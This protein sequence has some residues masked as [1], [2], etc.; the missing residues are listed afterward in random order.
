M[1]IS[2]LL[3]LV[4]VDGSHK[5][6][7]LAGDNPI[8][9]AI[10][11]FFVMLILA[12]VELVVLIP[13]LSDGE[14]ETLKAVEHCALVVAIA[15]AGIA[16]GLQRTVVFSE[17][18][19]G[20]TR[21]HFED[22]QHESAHQEAGICQLGWVVTGAVVEDARRCLWILAVR[23][24]QLCQFSAETVHH[25]Q[26]Q[27]PEILVERHVDQVVVDVKEEGVLVVLRRLAI[28]NPV[29][30]IG[31]DLNRLSKGSYFKRLSCLRRS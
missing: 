26:V 30:S 6:D 12:C 18:F 29:E 15:L 14:F 9:V 7:E 5:S 20:L 2:G 1:A 17:N 25:R 31:N 11:N 19:I 10:L 27:W 13:T 4:T 21:L 24:V 22:D 23:F 8:K 28:G 16:E 3:T